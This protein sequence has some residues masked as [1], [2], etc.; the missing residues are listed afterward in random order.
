MRSGAGV[1]RMTQFVVMTSLSA[2]RWSLCRCVISTAV[3]IGG[4][5]PAAVR[6]ISNPR[7]QSTRSVASADWT[8]VDGPARC[9]SGIGLPV[10]SSVIF[11]G[12]TPIRR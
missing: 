11:I 7:P 9:E 6:R 2:V 8:S 4:I 3:S 12:P 10:P 1:G 5:T